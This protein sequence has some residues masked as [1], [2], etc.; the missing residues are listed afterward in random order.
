MAAKKR[1]DLVMLAV[2]IPKELAKKLKVQAAQ[3]GF[4]LQHLVGVMLEMG[5]KRSIPR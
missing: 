4:P 5:S 1:D 2:R 3:Q